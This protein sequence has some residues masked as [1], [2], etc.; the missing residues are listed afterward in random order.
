MGQIYKYEHVVMMGVTSLSTSKTYMHS[1]LWYY[2]SYSPYTV[3][4]L[5]PTYATPTLTPPL[6]HNA[7]FIY[8]AHTYKSGPCIQIRSI[9]INLGQMILYL[10]HY[11]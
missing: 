11:I 3:P 6:L 9:F 5:R 10:A 8:L 1:I 2:S 4:T 7:R